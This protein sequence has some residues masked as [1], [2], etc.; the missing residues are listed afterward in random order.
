MSEDL[1]IRRKNEYQKKGTTLIPFDEGINPFSNEDFK[2]LFEYCEKVEKEFIEI[3]DAGEINNL[4]V[5]RFMS[6]KNKP[7]VVDNPYS[8]KL[9]EILGKKSFVDLIKNILSLKNE[10]YLR[11]VQYNQINKGNFVG[12]HL[13]TDSN[14]DYLAACVIQLGENFDGGIYRVFQKDKSYNDFHPTKGS[15]II[16]N[17]N[18]PHEVTKVTSGER[19]SLVFFISNHYGDNKRYS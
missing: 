6:D 16:S 9:L 8:K 3:G 1:I 19:K 14:P 18:Y 11:R 12:Y 10:F 4:M 5:A 13:D 2:N 17:C 7:E 15:L